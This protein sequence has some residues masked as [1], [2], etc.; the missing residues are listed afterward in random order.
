M[1]RPFAS[2]TTGLDRG[3]RSHLLE[4]GQPSA[5]QIAGLALL[6]IVRQN[7]LIGFARFGTAKRFIQLPQLDQGTGRD[8]AIVPVLLDQGLQTV[9]RDLQIPPDVSFV[10][11]PFEEYGRVLGLGRER[12]GK[13]H[14]A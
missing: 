3:C 11:S 2:E 9:D 13:E 8:R 5:G 6:G 4:R 12:R 14:Q 10:A 1:P 7:S